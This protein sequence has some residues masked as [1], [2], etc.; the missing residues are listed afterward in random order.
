MHE[1]LAR[2]GELGWLGRDLFAIE[3]A[4]EESL[5][6]AIR[7][8]NQFDLEKQVYIE[9]KVSSERFWLRVEDE[10]EGF[11][12]QDVPDCTDDDH[13]E[14]CGGRGLLLIKSYMNYVKHNECG[15]CVTMEKVRVCEAEVDGELDGAMD[16]EVDE[17][18]VDAARD[19]EDDVE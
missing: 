10:G 19:D 11:I 6:N 18:E 9:C 3:M 15:N 4:L 2:L 8:G 13:I 5:T 12:L 16:T 7:H 1:I 17:E 14:A